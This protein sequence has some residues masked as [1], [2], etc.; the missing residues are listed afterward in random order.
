[1]NE[2][3]VSSQEDDAL[4]SALRWLLGATAAA[5]LLTL[6]MTCAYRVG[7]PYPLE[8]MEGTSL[9]HALWLARG[10]LPY[11][12]PTAELIA[13]VYPPLAYL[14][15]ALASLLLGPSLPVA[16]ALS[17]MCTL[18]TL[19]LL[20]IA[21]ARL[22]HSRV[23]GLFSAGLFAYGFGYGGAFLDL[24][25]VD[26]LFV[27][28][29]AAAVERLSA[30]RSAAA[31]GW[32]VVSA[33]AKQHGAVL[34]LA[35]SLALLAY[36]RKSA[37]RSVGAAWLAL[38]AACGALQ[39]ASG[40]WFARYTL[41]VP[42]RHGLQPQL[43]ATFV[44]IDL[45]VYLPVLTISAAL[46]LGRRVRA[47]GPLDALALAAV[48]VSAL[49]RAHPGGDDNVRLPAFALLCV[50]GV[51][52]LVA[53]A[54]ESRRPLVRIGLA[55]ALC[56]QA[57]VLWQPPALHAPLLETARRFV[58]LDRELA[59]CAAGGPSVALDYGLFTSTPFIHTMALSDLRLGGASAL[60]AAGTSALLD[61]LRSP[62]APHAVAVGERFPELQR[63]LDERYTPCAELPAPR[64]PTGY[65]PGLRGA[66]G[67]L[68]QQ[69][70]ALRQR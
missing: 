49:G 31:L 26:G 58:A 57:A 63:V 50:V 30:H 69:V 42:S 25:R 18:G 64:L 40:G 21:S 27:L 51:A 3:A 12:A 2:E 22:A 61:A 45:M 46:A 39:L 35:V 7:W 62:D 9:Q 20:G 37:V 70:Y 33:L 52:P 60:S 24:V 5:G 32:L 19:V 10:Q 8:W 65:Q 67:E 38:A 15:P 44:L 55:L 17:L 28:C 14:P 13:Y 34:L 11:A 53:R 4:S 36:D 66:N 48:V 56:L 23:A 54:L 16:R 59:R 29:I 43:L 6:L 47:L 68:R 41:E 1:M